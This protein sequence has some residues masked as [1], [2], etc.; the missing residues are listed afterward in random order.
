MASRYIE[1]YDFFM[2]FLHWSGMQW[3]G[4]QLFQKR[5]LPN[6]SLH[7]I[8]HY[9]LSTRCRIS[10]Q[11]SFWSRFVSENIRPREE[12]RDA[13]YQQFNQTF[14]GFKKKKKKM[15]VR[16]EIYKQ[17]SYL[18]KHQRGKSW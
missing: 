9:K 11:F 4:F 14:P 17:K 15:Y 18:N 12:T 8:N 1:Y 13:I 6:S 16:M 5:F 2:V 10:Q 7:T 3:Q